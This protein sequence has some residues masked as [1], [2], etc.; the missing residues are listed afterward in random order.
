MTTVKPRL[1]DKIRKFSQEVAIADRNY[2]IKDAD[3]Y[4]FNDGK[5]V[6]KDKV[7]RQGY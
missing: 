4:S 7:D 6:F 5:R 3:A 2:Q 1:P